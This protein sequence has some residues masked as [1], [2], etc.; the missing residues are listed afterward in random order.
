M[1]VTDDGRRACD[2]LAALREQV[3]RHDP[4]LIYLDGNSLGM[5]PAASRQRLSRVVDQE[6]GGELVRGWSH[7]SELSADVG[8]RLGRELLG[9]AAGQVVVCDSISVNLYKLAT[10][11]LHHARRHDPGRRVLVTDASTVPTDRYVLAVAEQAGASVREVVPHPVEGITPD[12]LAEALT[13]GDVALVVLQLV[14]Y[15]SAALLDL[16]AT[17][18]QVHEA[19][20][21]VL[22][23]LAHAAGAV[24][25]DLDAAGAD[26]A[27]GCTYKYLDAGPGA[28]GFLHVAAA[29]TVDDAFVSP[30]PGWWGAHD[31]FD[32]D[33]P[34]R[35]AA[36]ASRFLAGSPPVLTL[37]AVD[38]GVR[39][40]AEAGIDR[41]ARPRCTSPSGSWP[42]RRAAWLRWGSPWPPP[43][44]LPRGRHVVLSHPRPT[45]SGPR[46]WP[47]AWSA[48][49]V[50]RT[51]C[52]WPRCPSRSTRRAWWRGSRGCATSWRP[53]STWTCPH[54]GH[55]SP[56]AARR[57]C[58]CFA[59]TAGSPMTSCRARRGRRTP[60][61]SSASGPPA[62]T[63]PN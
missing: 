48:T 41:Y 62:R 46:R 47:A 20:A 36:G 34:Y 5:L 54:G 26:L 63:S 56:D 15:R 40:L 8:D 19:G 55:G 7:W 50:R 31:P 44:A 12:G 13:P 21:L 45:G 30:I 61:G 2:E 4:A 17:T 29:L 35:P 38:E 3:V 22:W 24:P 37:V 59:A 33:A 42:R 1:T 43:R 27:V 14:D 9:S 6:W 51:C 57:L 16:D 28:P 25:V 58:P 39:L 53:G 10:A 11:A 23:Q 60:A 32:M 18:A 52:G 49:S